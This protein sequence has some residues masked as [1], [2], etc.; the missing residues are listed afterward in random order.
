MDQASITKQTR[1]TGPISI[2]GV[3]K[4]SSYQSS[5][6]II[7]QGWPSWVLL[8]TT[9]NVHSTRVF[10]SSLE[11]PWTKSLK[12]AFPLVSFRSVDALRPA[13]CQQSAVLLIQG[14]A[15]W[16][17]HLPTF[18]W[19][20]PQQIVCTSANQLPRM[21]QHAV[22]SQALT[23]MSCGGVTSG[24][25][26]VLFCGQMPSGNVDPQSLPRRLR[27]VINSTVQPASRLPNTPAPSD[28]ARQFDKP[29]YV[30]SNRTTLD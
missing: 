4:L 15:E 14:S 21:A 23:H 16:I 20:G 6:V 3:L 8:G 24:S 28:D 12:L 18:V 27:H 19:T 9:I 2:Q 17:D 13:V 26:T 11:P 25:F 1:H 10:L 7:S 5:V 29:W 30:D 22:G